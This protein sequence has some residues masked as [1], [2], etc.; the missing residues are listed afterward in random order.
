MAEVPATAPG[1]SIE[2]RIAALEAIP[3]LER[4]LTIFVAGATGFVGTELVVRLVRAGHQLRIVTRHAKHADALLP[5]A[6]V[7]VGAGNVHDI[8]FLR[9]CLIGCDVAI[10]LVGALH[11]PGRGGLRRVHVQ[12]TAALLTAMAEAGVPRL[13]Q[14]SA[15]HADPRGRSHYLRTKGEAE[16]LLR[17]APPRLQWTIFR[18]SVIFGAGD[19]LT[20][21]F[22]SL[23]RR[24]HGWLPLARARTRFAPIHV[25]DVASAFMRALRGGTANR[26]TYEL[27]GPE[28]MT[29]EQ[30]VRVSAAAAAHPCRVLPLPDALGWLQGAILQCVPGKPFTLDNFRSLGVDSVCTTSGCERLGIQPVSLPALA[31]LWLAPGRAHAL[32]PIR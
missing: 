6:S 7:E 1:A 25:A 20:T 27:C 4:P 29:L 16:E 19:S 11:A 15:L 18:P 14:M 21:R 13:L 32:E 8:D 3:H 9:R 5:L 23:L 2:A 31:P 24:T 17:A 12:F 26:Q 10:N 22:A 28:V 30:I